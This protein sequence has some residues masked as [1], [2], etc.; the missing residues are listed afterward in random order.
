MTLDITDSRHLPLRRSD[1]LSPTMDE[2]VAAVGTE[3]SAAGTAGRADF[4]DAQR[5]VC[6]ESY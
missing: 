5:V 1:V 6:E 4:R 3:N 2:G